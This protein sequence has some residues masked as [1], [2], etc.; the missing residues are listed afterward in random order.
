MLA[1]PVAQCRQAMSAVTVFQRWVSVSPGRQFLSKPV[2]PQESCARQHIHFQNVTDRIAQ[3]SS[4]QALAERQ[5]S[6][7]RLLPAQQGV[8]ATH[9]ASPHLTNNCVVKTCQAHKH[10][11]KNTLL[12]QMGFVWSIEQCECCVSSVRVRPLGDHANLGDCF[13]LLV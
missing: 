6:A 1:L 2:R 3:C 9:T 5:E 7:F 8:A 10:I 4:Q 11:T 13:G 12:D